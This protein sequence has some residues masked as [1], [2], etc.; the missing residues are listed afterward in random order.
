M[1]LV[2]MMHSCSPGKCTGFMHYADRTGVHQ[3]PRVGMMLEWSTG[4]LL[5]RAAFMQHD[6][7]GHYALK[8][9][10]A[11]KG[12]RYRDLHTLMEFSPLM[13]YG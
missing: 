7:K 8:Y 12:L 5:G 11:F 13:V 1:S 10:A 4:E 3:P 6:D 2:V 9:Y